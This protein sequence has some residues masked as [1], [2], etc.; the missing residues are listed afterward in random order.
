MPTQAPLTPGSSS[1]DGCSWIGATMWGFSRM[2]RD[3]SAGSSRR[4][5]T[6]CRSGAPSIAAFA[7]PLLLRFGRDDVLAIDFLLRP[8]NAAPV[9][10]IGDR[11]ATLDA[12][13]DPLARLGFLGEELL[14]Q[15]HH[16]PPTTF[17][18]STAQSVGN[19]GYYE[20]KR[21]R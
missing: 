3:F 5:R 14:E 1:A 7:D 21:G 6:C 20:E 18:G 15:G 13:P 4:S 16:E 10:V 8:E 11:H 19:G 17:D 12:N 9:L 2:R